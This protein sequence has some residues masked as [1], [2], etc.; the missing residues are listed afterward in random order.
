[1]YKLADAIHSHG[2]SLEPPKV[3][4]TARVPIIKMREAKSRIDVD[5]AFGVASGVENSQLINR[6][7]KEV[8][9]LVHLASSSLF[10]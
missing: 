4:S 6:L 1:M 7:L 2:I 9:H 3:I 10:D 5:I 8:K